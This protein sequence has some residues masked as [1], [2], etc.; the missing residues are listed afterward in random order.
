MRV[1]L[2]I[3]GSLDTVSGGYLYD[4]KLVQHLRRQGDAVE[5]ISLPW[6][7]YG[8][9]LADNFSRELRTRLLGLGV[10]VLLQDE[11]NHPSLAW[12]NASLRGR[13][14]FPLVSIV[15]H[16]RAS[17]EHPAVAHALYR[18]V[19]RRYLNSVDGFICNSRTTQ[20]TVAAHSPH[21]RPV[22]VAYPAADHVQP[23]AGADAGRE[24][25][26][27]LETKGPLHV[28]FVGNVI[29]RKGLHSLLNSLARLP[30][31]AWRLTVAGSLSVD[32]GYVA[33]IRRQID[34]LHLGQQVTLCGAVADSELRALYHRSH[35]LAMPSYEGFGIAY[36]EAMGF[37]LPVIASTAGAAREVITHGVDGYLAAP[38]DVTAIAGHLQSWLDDRTLLIA[39]SL[40]ARLRY[41]RHPTWQDSG[42]RIRDWLLEFTGGR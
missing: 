21:L 32:P 41:D 24:I 37:G 25:A 15:H 36:L 26:Q 2:V 13:I 20:A 29:A 22:V 39:M 11:L 23:P 9:H 12:L 28:L 6:R 1:G 31:E 10:D 27:R 14:P 3:Y 17:E 4:R 8:R 33:S 5:I 34:G 35:V 7:S 38:G 30:R 16:L 18:Q 19:E 40:N 42:A